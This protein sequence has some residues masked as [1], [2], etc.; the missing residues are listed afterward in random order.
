MSMTD[1]KALTDSCSIEA[2]KLPAAPALFSSLASILKVLVVPHE[3]DIVDGT[4]LLGT[5]LRGILQVVELAHIH[6]ANANHLR[7]RANG[8]NCLSGTLGLLYIATDDACV[9]TQMDKRAH[10]G[11]ADGAGATGAED[12]L[13]GCRGSATR[14]QPQGR[15]TDRRCHPSRCRSYTRTLLGP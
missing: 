9:C 6:R 8:R 10:L 15:E 11:A 1:L 5:T 4:E 2:K 14:V 3:H 13:I 12:D 7:S